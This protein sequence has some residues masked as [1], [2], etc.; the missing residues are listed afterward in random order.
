M[1]P[2]VEDCGI[3][4][5]TEETV[6]GFFFKKA[7][8]DGWDNLIGLVVLN[9]GYL[10]VL[11]G[12]YG[13]MTVAS[14]NAWL[15]ILCVIAVIALY[16]LYTGAV[17]YQCHAYSNYTR[18]GWSGFK[19]GMVRMWRHSMIYFALSALVFL[20]IMFVIPFYFSYNNMI[21][22]ILSIILFWV[23]LAILL[24]LMYFFPLACMMPGDRPLKTLKKSFMV[25]ADNLWFS[26]FLGLYTL[27]CFV[28]TVIVAGLIPGVA[29]ITLAQMDAMKLLMF[30]YDYFEANP[31]APRKH[32][33][34]E[35]LLFD[36]REKVGHRSLRNMIFPWKD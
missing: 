13:A 26:V 8:F 1:V 9:L 35:E 11:A 20:L 34:W 24:A 36:E 32:L 18:G 3:R 6:V 22:F 33:P 4:G 30:K 5:G 12:L 31:E 21:G 15:G 17:A 27:V 16:S 25:V 14:M 2:D 7:F 10:V 29:G 28:L 19:E 23:F